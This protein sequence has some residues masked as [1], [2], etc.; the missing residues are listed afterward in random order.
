MTGPFNWTAGDISAGQTLLDTDHLYPVHINELRT[1]MNNR[2]VVNVMDYGATGD[3][4]TDDSTAIIA[5]IAA[6]KTLKLPVFFPDKHYAISQSLLIDSAD[7]KVISDPG[8]LLIGI[9]AVT[10]CFQIYAA[11]NFNCRWSLPQMTD[12]AAGAAIHIKGANLLDIYAPQISGCADGILIEFD[13]TFVNSV[14]NIIS[15]IMINNCTNGI[16]MKLN[17]NTD[18]MQGYRFNFN[19]FQ[20]CTKCIYFDGA[21]L[22]P[23][24]VIMNLFAIDCLDG[25]YT[26]NSY[27]IYAD[28]PINVHRF[29]VKNSFG[30]FAT[31][32]V[33]IDGNYNVFDFTTSATA[34]YI[35]TLLNIRGVG[36]R[37][38][39]GDNAGYV[40]VPIAAVTTS[41]DLANF[42]GG[43]ML[44]TNKN[45]IKLTLGVQLNAGSTKDFY[46]F[47]GCVDGYSN[48][49]SIQPVYV[50]KAC[51]ITALNDETTN[52]GVDGA[53]V[54]NQILIRLHALENMPA[55]DYTFLLK[56]NG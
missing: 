31:N 20:V 3:G 13:D 51:V 47:S 17:A 10:D 54:A 28:C 15:G 44:I 52:A 32:G 41:N 37:I 34:D 42:N 50:N 24:D 49:I 18:Q 55:A 45:I 21:G 40:T 30:G 4:V 5:T 6:A 19:F 9:G 14:D 48:N 35:N 23:T 53:I 7:I 38:I 26:A 33:R 22:N 25:G 46:V 12:F 8:A 16:R 11:A 29:E 56:V 43:K 27:G 2:G 36:N 1:A 39:V